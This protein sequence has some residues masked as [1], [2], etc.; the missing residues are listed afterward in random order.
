VP[1]PKLKHRS[2]EPCD[3]FLGVSLA[4]LDGQQLYLSGELL[5]GFQFLA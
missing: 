2:V 5:E 4:E 1:F 3:G